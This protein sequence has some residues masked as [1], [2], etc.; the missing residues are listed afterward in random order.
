MEGALCLVMKQQI[1]IVAGR[2][3]HILTFLDDKQCLILKVFPTA[4]HE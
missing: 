1:Q 4:T 3:A 2:M